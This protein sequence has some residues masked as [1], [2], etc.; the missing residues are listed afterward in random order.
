MAGWQDDPVV[1]GAPAAAASSGGGGWQNDPIVGGKAIAQ[2]SSSDTDYSKSPWSA[3]AR[4]LAESA[5]LGAGDLIYSHLA[6][7]SLAR[8]Q[9]KTQAAEQSLPWYERYPLEGA[10]YML[11]AGS[12]LSGV[13]EAL[14]IGGIGAAALEG[15]LAG[16][17]SAALHSNDP[18][19]TDVGMGAAGG[20][21]LGGVAGGLTKGVNTGLQKTFG[22]AASVDPEVAIA[23]TDA[24][25]TAKYADLHA[26]S[27]PTF[28]PQTVSDAYVNSINDLTNVQKGDVNKSF[29]QKMQDHVDQMKQT[30]DVSAGA[31]DEYARSIQNAASPTNNAEQIL[32][33]KL[34]DRLTGENG[35][36][37]TAPTTSGHPVGQAYSML[38]DA[39]D[40]YQQYMMAQNLSKWQRTTASGGSAGQAPLTEAENFYQDDPEKYQALGAAY[41][42]SQHPPFL[43][44]ALGHIAANATGALGGA[45]AGFPG[46]A[47]GEALGYIYAKPAIYKAMKGY[48]RG[49]MQKAYQ[50]LYPQFT[51][52]QPTGG[53]QAPQMSGNL[54]K[55]LMLGGA[56]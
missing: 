45:I 17:A 21:L 42:K 15:G 22:K 36:L 35:V 49:Q 23:Q 28:A 13:P 47:V 14:G 2:A 7:T 9:A 33:A 18:S 20:A 1:G 31:V 29:M 32:A 8:E 39:K 44:S 30:G 48:N 50:Q 37:A 46:A 26:P 52:V 3:A 55:N 56:Y 11:G 5:S 19:L 34:R 53:V 43:T 25:Q 10:G 41:E 24:N 4:T 16:G 12:L 27:A 40:A 51:G 54:I 6:G 38:G